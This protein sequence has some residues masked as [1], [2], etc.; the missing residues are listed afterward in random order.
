M[1]IYKTLLPHTNILSKLFINIF[2]ICAIFPYID[3][4]EFTMHCIIIFYVC[5][6]SVVSDSLWPRGCSLLGSFVHVTFQGRILEWVAASYSRGSPQPRDGTPVSLVSC[7][8]SWILYHELH[9]LYIIQ[10]W[11][12][13]LHNHAF[14]CTSSYFYMME[15]QKCFS[16]TIVCVYLVT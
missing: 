7:T 8:G 9:L 16:A 4:S 3:L 11:S 1:Y 6:R 2:N 5:S 10:A 13:N 12:A 14:F 15:S